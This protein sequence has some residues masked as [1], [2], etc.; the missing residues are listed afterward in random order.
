LIRSLAG[1]AGATLPDG[2]RVR[3]AHACARRF[4]MDQ[5]EPVAMAGGLPGFRKAAAAD[6]SLPFG[7]SAA[8]E[9]IRAEMSPK[10]GTEPAGTF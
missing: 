7:L 8:A 1:R 9:L 4:A 6:E 5:P 3:I 10:Q 2:G